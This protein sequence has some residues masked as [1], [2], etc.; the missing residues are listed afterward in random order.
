VQKRATVA[1]QLSGDQEEGDG[2]G[3]MLWLWQSQPELWFLGF[4]N[5][6]MR[7]FHSID[8][9]MKNNPKALPDNAESYNFIFRLS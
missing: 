2:E 7:S 8:C 6:V 5:K 3:T 4:T 1:A 9:A